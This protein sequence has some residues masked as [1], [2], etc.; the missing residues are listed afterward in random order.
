MK[1][2]P[3]VVVVSLQQDRNSIQSCTKDIRNSD[4]N[5]VK[6][7]VTIF[8]HLLEIATRIVRGVVYA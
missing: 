2:S 3:I 1:F 7:G 8:P 4:L 6:F 5:V